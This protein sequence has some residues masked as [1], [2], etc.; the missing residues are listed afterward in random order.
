MIFN[1][2]RLILNVICSVVFAGSSF[3]AE[4]HIGAGQTYTTIADFNWRSL[5]A[6]DHVYIHPGTY[7]NMIWL[8][9]SGT[10]ANPIIIEGVPD[11]SGNLPV[12]DGN[13]MVIP[14]SYDGHLSEYDLGGGKLAQGYGMV[15]FHWSTTEWGAEPNWIVVKNFEI[16]RTTPESYT[17]TNT[18]NVVQSYPD[19]NAGVYLRTGNHITLENLIIHD[20][21][22]GIESQGVDEMIHDLTIR[23]CW[24]YE[25]GRTG[26]RQYFEHGMYNETSGMIAEYNV[27]G[28]PRDGTYGAT[29]KDRGAGTVIR[30]NIIHPNARLLD[31]VEPENQSSY[32]C[33]GSNYVAGKMHDE[34]NFGHTYVYGNTFINRKVGVKPI[35][36][37]L[38]HYG[39]D[40]CQDIS[41]NGTLH[42][43][44][45][46]V[47]HDL[48][49][50]DQYN[51]SLF[52]LAPTGT[53][54]ARN[55][56]ILNMGTS[57]FH[58]AYHS[59]ST[60]TGTYN[61]LGGN[62]VSRPYQDVRTGYTA[63][64]WNETATI[65]DGNVT[66]G[67]VV[68]AASNDVHIVAGSPLINAGVSLPAGYATAGHAVDKQY[69]ATR[70]Y[71]ARANTIDIGAYLYTEGAPL[72]AGR[73]YRYLSISGD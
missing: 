8:S 43:Y 60:T 69:L 28:P 58:M 59:K 71:E 53:I 47:V 62:Y 57:Y 65:I 41:R 27:V 37:Y 34:P 64:A 52:D 5:A 12:L 45:N 56:N 36:G 38:I 13:N 24:I 19:S 42:F 51:S 63:A 16:K 33:N 21:G 35:A 31:L 39:Y 32:A 2:I 70:T 50:S 30:Y 11:E 48:L 4:Y 55:N 22:N 1:M 20:V 3:A 23:G 14:S 67:V 15:F 25:F 73:R 26:S 66:S 61:W 40:N 6:G 18:N 10:E 44:N 68:D 9:K 7:N 72:P 49:S 46:T 54:N 17:F 29:I